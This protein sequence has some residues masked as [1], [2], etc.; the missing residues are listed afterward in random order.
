MKDARYL[1]D[2]V[3]DQHFH[4]VVARRVGF[5][6]VQP[7]FKLREGVASRDIVDCPDKRNM[8]VPLRPSSHKASAS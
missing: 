8:L 3:P 6:L 7:V 5:Q 2:F 1:I 4:D